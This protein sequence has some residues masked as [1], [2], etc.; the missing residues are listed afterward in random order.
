[1]PSGGEIW[2]VLV[3]GWTLNYEM[4]FYAVFAGALLLPSRLRLATLACL[5]V[6]LASLGLIIKSPAP[7]LS[8]YTD[9]IILGFLLGALI[10][11][12][13]L[14]GKMP[15]PRVGLGLI[16][17][18]LLGFAFVGITYVG[19]TSLVFGP[20]AAA[21]VVGVLALERAGSLGHLGSLS[22]LGDGS[23]SIY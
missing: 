3:Q 7:L 19:F 6:P 1:S 17:I 9:P 16:A 11:K 2:P 22:Y 18:A 15:S 12:Y 8:T 14:A 20:L 23:Y 10:G 5:F 4:F 13:W 21:L